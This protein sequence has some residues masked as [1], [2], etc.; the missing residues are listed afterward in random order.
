LSLPPQE[1]KLYKDLLQASKGIV[2]K[3]RMKI[4][5]GQS[6]TRLY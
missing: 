5:S 2:T 4:A 1:K 3:N 6:D